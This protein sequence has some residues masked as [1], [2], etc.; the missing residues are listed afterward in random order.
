MAYS[1]ISGPSSVF[2]YGDVHKACTD[3]QVLMNPVSGVPWFVCNDCRVTGQL[4]V[5]GNRISEVEAR[6]AR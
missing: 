1:T 5:V 2:E 6:N 3:V 4:D